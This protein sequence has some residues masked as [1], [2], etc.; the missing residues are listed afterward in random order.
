MSCT[1]IW[2]FY[3]PFWRHRHLKADVLLLG[4]DTTFYRP[5]DYRSGWYHGGKGR[6]LA[7][8]GDAFVNGLMQWSFKFR[9]TYYKWV[10]HQYQ[11]IWLNLNDYS[12]IDIGPYKLFLVSLF[13]ELW[14]Q[15]SAC[16]PR[17]DPFFWWTCLFSDKLCHGMPKTDFVY[18]YILLY[19]IINIYIYIYSSWC[20]STVINWCVL[21]R[22]DQTAYC[23]RLSSGQN[24]QAGSLCKCCFSWT[25]QPP[26]S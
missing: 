2:N 9:I 6:A 14:V 24:H 26:P 3:W 12:F 10:W 22:C 19:I 23:S 13:D 1:F 11:W 17:I 7:I 25:T 8:W 5:S 16:C 4:R 18:Y 21:S 20:N 15:C